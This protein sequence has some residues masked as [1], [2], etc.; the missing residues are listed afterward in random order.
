M[1][2]PQ[3]EQIASCA[4]KHALGKA[5]GAASEGQELRAVPCAALSS[6]GELVHLDCGD[7]FPLQVII[8]LPQANVPFQHTEP[9]VLLLASWLSC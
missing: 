8:T 6:A 1:A 9:I 5:A 4:Q 7:N 2:V 3:H